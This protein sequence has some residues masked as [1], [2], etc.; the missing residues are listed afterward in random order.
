[1]GEPMNKDHQLIADLLSALEYH[2]EQTRPI[3]STTVAIQAARE[4]LRTI[5][6][7]LVSA[8]TQTQAQ[9]NHERAERL[10]AELAA[11]NE[12][13]TFLTNM[14]R[15][16]YQMARLYGDEWTKAKERIA[17]LE[18]KLTFAESEVTQLVFASPIYRAA[19]SALNGVKAW[20]DCDG[21]D[22]FPHKVREQID[23]ILLAYEAR[24]NDIAM[25]KGE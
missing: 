4:H 5:S 16:A 6:Q 19:V 18:H 22:G 2:A 7:Q 17:E 3:H 11:A 13:A 20:R 10:K 15:E 25:R 8:Q 9:E 14:H 24:L 21:N 12:R 23:A 1:M